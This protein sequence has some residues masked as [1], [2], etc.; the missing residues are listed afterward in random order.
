MW[1]LIWWFINPG[2][3]QVLHREVYPT[4]ATCE[5]AGGRLPAH[6]AAVRWHCSQE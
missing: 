5:I 1:I 3:E 6:N 2:H 4:Q